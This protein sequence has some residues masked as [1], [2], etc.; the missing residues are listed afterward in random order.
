MVR[1]NKSAAPVRYVV[2]YEFG[3]SPYYGALQVTGGDQLQLETRHGSKAARLN[4]T[5]DVR[6]LTMV[7]LLELGAKLVSIN[8]HAS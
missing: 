4:P 1:K 8:S 7:L 6:S 2:N 5:S 3:G